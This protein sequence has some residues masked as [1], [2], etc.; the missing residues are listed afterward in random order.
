MTCRCSEYQGNTAEMP[1][2][3]SS[4]RPKPR[5]T[6]DYLREREELRQMAAKDMKEKGLVPPDDGGGS[7][8]GDGG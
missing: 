8:E 7:G 4:A 6:D 3:A 2:F 1:G 5:T